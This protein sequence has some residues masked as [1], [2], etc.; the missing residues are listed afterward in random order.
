MLEFYHLLNLEVNDF[1]SLELYVFVI[2]TMVIMKHLKYDIIIYLKDK[3]LLI[4]SL[5]KVY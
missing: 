2:G 1:S 3:R 4:A 5:Y